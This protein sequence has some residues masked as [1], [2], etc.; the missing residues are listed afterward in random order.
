MDYQRVS[1]EEKERLLESL[2]ELEKKVLYRI[3]VLKKNPKQ[4]SKELGYTEN[5]IRNQLTSIYEKFGF[6][7]LPDQTKRPALKAEYTEL[8]KRFKKEEDFLNWTRPIQSTPQSVKVLIAAEGIISGNQSCLIELAESDP[9]AYQA[10]FEI[11]VDTASDPS[12][13]GMA[14][15]LL[16]VG[17]KIKLAAAANSNDCHR[18]SWGQ[19]SDHGRST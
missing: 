17:K 13:L 2:S 19:G 7:H 9:D 3:L 4:I 14:S 10:A 12:I 16:Y 18:D 6:A 5:Y 15:H 11:I 1:R 8:V